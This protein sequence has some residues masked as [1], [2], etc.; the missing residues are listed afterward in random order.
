MLC[1][2]ASFMSKARFHLLAALFA[3]STVAWGDTYIL[4]GGEKVEGNTISETDK[5]ITLQIAITATIKDERIIKKADVIS[6]KKIAPDEQAWPTLK[7][8]ALGDESLELADYMQATTKLGTF[9]SLYPQSSHATEAKAKLG[10][11][12]AEKKRVEAGELKI[13]GKWL[14]AEEAEQEKVQIGGKILLSRMKQ[15]A[16]AAQYPETL[17]VFDALEKNYPGCAAM[18]DAV[19]IA[20]KAI[21]SLKLAAEQRQ[22]QLK[23]YTLEIAARLAN[24]RSP[25]REQ[26]EAV[27]KKN[28]AAIESVVV[29]AEHSGAIWLPLSPANDRSLT[30][31]IAKCTSELTRINALP[32]DKMRQSLKSVAKAK[33]AF[34]NNDI[35]AVEKALIEA[36][37]AWS[38]NELVKRLQ[39]KLAD[40]RVKAIEAAKVAEIEKVAAT[41]ANA[42]RLIKLKAEAEKAETEAKK[43]KD[44][45]LAREAEI[46]AKAQEGID[47]ESR[48]RMIIKYSLGAIPVVL[49]CIFVMRKKASAKTEEPPQNTPAENPPAE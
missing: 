35:A 18:P 29:A 4:K 23:Q 11:F 1:F 15:F 25:E 33:A 45:Q 40:E 5:E 48:N 20:R 49:L 37:T 7:A 8:L 12:E 34:E 10:L 16:A 38:T 19:D 46:E 24:T 39:Q 6:V 13:G 14:G 26:V 30:A 28:L 9:A 2:I 27:Q 36:N 31:L 17:N 44:D 21:P 43:I 41:K 3:L 22:T 47:R 42:E 32:A